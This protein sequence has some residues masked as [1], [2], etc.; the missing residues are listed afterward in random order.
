MTG[1]EAGTLHDGP[2]APGAEDLVAGTWSL[3][4]LVCRALRGRPVSPHRRP[5]LFRDRED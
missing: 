5:P 3:T 2:P 4:G 1:T